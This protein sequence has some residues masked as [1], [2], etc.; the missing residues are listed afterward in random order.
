[1]ACMSGRLRLPGGMQVPGDSEL[2]DTLAVSA[3]ARWVLEN[4][5]QKISECTS[6]S[7]RAATSSMIDLIT[8]L[9][10]RFDHLFLRKILSE[11][12]VHELTLVH[13]STFGY[14]LTTFGTSNDTMYSYRMKTPGN[15]FSQSWLDFLSPF[16]KGGFVLTREEPNSDPMDSAQNGTSEKSLDVSMAE[17]NF[18][19]KLITRGC[20]FLS[21]ESLGVRISTCDSLT[22]G[23]RFLAFVACKYEVSP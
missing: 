1:M 5:V 23:F 11:D 22:S 6:W 4:A 19:S 21:H 13:K 3:S 2:E 9:V 7:D 12:E 14:F 15:C 17:I 18:L 8:L 10:E 20:Y 16:R